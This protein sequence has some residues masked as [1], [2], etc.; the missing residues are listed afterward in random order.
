MSDPDIKTVLNSATARE[1]YQALQRQD[2]PMAYFRDEDLKAELARREAMQKRRA[3][4]ARRDCNDRIADQAALLLE[5]FEPAH[6]PDNCCSDDQPHD[7]M[8]DDGVLCLRCVLVRAAAG[9]PIYDSLEIRLAARPS[10]LPDP[11]LKPYWEHG[12]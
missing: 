9:K 10:V 3:L 12:K 11:D 4:E 2:F 8:A 7:Y 6:D 5:V 1:L